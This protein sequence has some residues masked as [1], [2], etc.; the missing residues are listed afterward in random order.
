MKYLIIGSVGSGK[1]TLSKKIVEKL[2]IDSYEIDSIVHDDK[3]K[4]KRTHN[5]QVELIKEI[6]EDR[7]W[8]MEGTLRKNL[9]FLL[10]MA[11]IIIYLD[12]SKFRIK[13]N[14]LTRFI[15]QKMQIE[16]CNYNPTLKMLSNMFK[17]AKQFEK[18]K[19]EFHNTLAVY[20]KKTIILRNRKEINN[21]I[22]KK[23]GG[24]KID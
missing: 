15:K 9:Y 17:W 24:E 18:N 19:K 13:K 16:K 7:E 22:N 10:D 4:I 1:T 8:I 20:H 21:Y 5:E 3:N 23:I 12:I 6:N 2:N 11:D 14:I